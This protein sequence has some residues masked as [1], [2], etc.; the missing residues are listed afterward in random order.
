M[1][2]YIKPVL[3]IYLILAGSVNL[4]GQIVSGLSEGIT[5]KF[6]SYCE[7]V[8]WEEVFVHTDRDDYMAGEELWMSAWLIDKASGSLSDNSRLVYVELLNPD[9]RPVV[10]KRFSLEKGSGPGLIILPD[11]LSPGQYTLRAYTNWMRNFHP[12][13]Y[14]KR[15]LNIYNALTDKEFIRTLDKPGTVSTDPEDAGKKTGFSAEIIDNEK[16]VAEICIKT[17]DDFRSKNGNFMH[18]F[19][20]TGGKVDIDRTFNLTHDSL[21]VSIREASLS[22]GINHITILNSLW[23]VLFERYLYTPAEDDRK[24]ELDCPSEAGLRS[25]ITVGSGTV[26]GPVQSRGRTHLSISAAPVR[27]PSLNTDIVDYLLIGSQFG[28]VP[29]NLRDSITGKLQPDLINTFLRTA[30]SRW[31]NWELILAGRLPELK[32]KMEKEDHYITGKLLN[33]ETG[34][35]EPEKYVFLSV[36]GKTAGF[37]YAKTDRDGDFSLSIPVNHSSRDLIIQP[38][39][40]GGNYSIRFGSYF[41]E[42][43]IPEGVKEKI[44]LNDLPDH[45]SDMFVNYQV[46]KI[47]GSSSKGEMSL[48]SDP[49][50]IAKRFYGK[51]DATII[52][53]DYIKLPVMEE[54]FY[55]LLPGVMMKK[56]RTGYEF[57]I[58]D[59]IDNYVYEVAPVLFIDG[60]VV[61]DAEV[62]ANLDPELV[63]Q[64]DVVRER[65]LV[66]DYVFYG[67]I[68]II[69]R[70]GDYSNVSLSDHALRLSYSAAE[71]VFQFT[72]PDYAS[73]QSKL[74][75]TPDFRNTLYWDADY[76]T[77]S[78]NRISFDLWTSDQPGDYEINI[79]G[80][81]SDGKPLSLRK[82]VKVR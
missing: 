78:D 52:M 61:N 39:G 53:D 79:Q 13:T 25:R 72:A 19:V 82:T 12:E 51:P 40:T 73:Q 27:K 30:K 59:P 37:Q 26:N 23:K 74:S 8:P 76:K 34:D 10:Q 38:E 45:I 36:P 81:A 56:R 24:F 49:A 44:I 77:E 3:L 54:V 7:A 47:Y 33:R 22:P 57:E 4:S 58:I 65:Y 2:R 50:I 64:I 16:E 69:T 18:I 42:E 14:F 6:R 32:Y 35:P 60:V 1:Y 28:P 62:I 17:D 29:D 70:R 15:K 11:S 46:R 80:I 63:E 5:E 66:G 21:T 31:I 41:S 9:S 20:H 43:Y 67:L 55:E 75:R 71:P 68:N 48:L